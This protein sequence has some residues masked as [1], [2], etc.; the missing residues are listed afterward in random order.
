[1]DDRAPPHGRREPTCRARLAAAVSAV[2]EAGIQGSHQRRLD[3]TWSW[4]LPDRG[5]RS[6]YIRRQRHVGRGR[7]PCGRLDPDGRRT[8]ERAAVDDLLAVL[9]RTRLLE[10]PPDD[11]RRRGPA[12]RVLGTMC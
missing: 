6:P 8:V 2:G 1:P 10:S 5:W 4:N 12:A 9:G 11:V 7:H 3:G